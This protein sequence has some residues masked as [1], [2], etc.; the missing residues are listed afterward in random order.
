EPPTSEQL[1]EWQ[2]RMS[3]PDNEFPAAVG[4]TALLARTD[5]AAVGITGIAAFSTG[6]QF[7]LG[8]RLRQPRADLVAGRLFMLINPD[9]Y[10]GIDV[11][12]AE[13]LLLGIEYA[14]GQRA[15]T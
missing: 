6:F 9:Q 11:S 3:P 7:T 13:Q 15:S 4:F 2:R 1:R 12:L 5:D 10:G 14:N 8:V